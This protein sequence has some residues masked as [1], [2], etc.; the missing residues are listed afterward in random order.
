MEVFSFVDL[1]KFDADT[2]TESQV[3]LA[4]SCWSFRIVP[5]TMLQ[6]HS[7]NK[8]CIYEIISLNLDQLFIECPWKIERQENTQFLAKYLSTF[9]GDLPTKYEMEAEPFSTKYVYD[10]RMFDFDQVDGACVQHFVCRTLWW[11]SALSWTTTSR[12]GANMRP[13]QI[14]FNL[15]WFALGTHDQQVLMSLGSGPIFA[16]KQPC[17]AWSR[18]EGQLIRRM[19]SHT[20][21]LFQRNPKS[22]R[23]GNHSRVVAF[24]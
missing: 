6:N 15:V 11:K 1:Q 2:I 4:D 17:Q 18:T 8:S 9:S 10:L 7:K 22:C 16:R 21:N 3:W 24:L 14:K 12:I 5:T 23:L 19:A 13:V 20:S